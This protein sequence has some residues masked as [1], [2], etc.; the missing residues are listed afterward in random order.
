[1]TSAAPVLVVGPAWVGDMVM[2]QSLFKV[3]KAR[4]PLAPIDVLAP[5]WSAPLISR[6]PQVRRMVTMPLGHGQLGLAERY[7]LG[8]KL[9][10]EGYGEAILLPNSLKSALTPFWANIPKRTGFVG[11]MRW[12]LLNHARKLD[13]SKLPRTVDRFIALG[14][15]PDTPL[16]DPLPLPQLQASPENARQVMARLGLADTDQPLLVLCPGAEY[17]PAKLWPGEY[18]GEVARNRIA[19]G[20]RVWVVGSPKDSATAAQ[21]TA[22][23]GEACQDLTGQTSLEEAVDLIA[24][25]HG[26]VTNDSGLMH[27]A[28]AL[29]RHVIALFGSSDPNHT[30]PLGVDV[31]VLSLGLACSPCFER[32]CPEQ[33]LNCLKDIPPGEVLNLLE[34]RSL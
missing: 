11:E 27:V 5:P 18:Y 22:R 14:Q 16:P 17:G 10:K 7:R 15:E 34:K 31:E 25:A 33:H 1:M 29:D 24:L 8:K 32:T 20:W 23:A 19:K 6:M 3:L 21:I 13:K 30:P 2:A 9:R 26:V 28:A 12:G 4:A